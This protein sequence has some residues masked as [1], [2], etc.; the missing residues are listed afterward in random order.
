M[1]K[2]FTVRMLTLQAMLA[3]LSII[4]TRFC[5]IPINESLRISFGNIPVLLSG[6]LGGPVAGALVG[7]VAD[8]IG[9]IFFNPFGWY[10]PLTLSPF[11]YGIIAG[12]FAK[13][14]TENQS[15]LKCLITALA[16]NACSTMTV[17]T[18]IL[19]QMQGLPSSL[20]LFAV[21]IPLYV[22]ITVCEALVLYLIYKSKILKK[23]G[24]LK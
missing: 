18:L 15:Y 3:A 12:L 16:C 5:Q 1:S 9:C 24:I 21:R 7:A 20:P 2:K 4:L 23:A 8:I 11:I 10:P 17:S 14:F 13:A 6:L 19:A 22:G